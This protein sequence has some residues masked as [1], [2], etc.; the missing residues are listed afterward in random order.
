MPSAV[1]APPLGPLQFP[2]IIYALGQ[3]RSDLTR[4][5]AIANLAAVKR[6]VFLLTNSDYANV[7]Q[8]QIIDDNLSIQ[9][10]S[11]EATE[12]A[13][14]AQVTQLFSVAPFVLVVDALPTG[15]YGELPNVLLA[16]SNIPKILILRDLKQEY[17]ISQNLK[18]LIEN[19]Y[20]LAIIPG[21]AEGTALADLPNVIQTGPW[22]SLANL[23]LSGGRAAGRQDAITSKE[24]T[25]AAGSDTTVLILASDATDELEV[26]GYIANTIAQ[27]CPWVK[28]RCLSSVPPTNCAVELWDSHWPAADYLS[29]ADLVIGEGDYTTV[30]LCHVLRTPL[31]A[32]PWS[33]S[34]DLQRERLEKMVALDEAAFKIVTSAEEALC[35][36][37]D[38]LNQGMEK[39]LFSPHKRW[40]RSCG[41][42]ATNLEGF[43]NG[44]QVGM[45]LIEEVLENKWNQVAY[46]AMAQDVNQLRLSGSA[47]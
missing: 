32:F 39:D 45:Q 26:Y 12:E 7:V 6:Q 20:D 22:I 23:G 25:P 14:V 1:L 28:V 41:K 27:Q 16:L 18:Y 37:F 42:D 40:Q 35:Q 5:V 24:P 43:N 17:I 2:W 3:N 46:A 10:I 13:V 19:Y 29:A 30:Y 34:G 11:P 47:S 38:F 36:T 8:S 15:F 31:I 44:V 4:S 9:Q 21:L 33:R